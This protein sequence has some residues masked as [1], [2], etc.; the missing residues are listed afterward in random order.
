[1]LD[2]LADVA[3]SHGIDADSFRPL[4]LAVEEVFANCVRHNPT[5]VGPIEVSVGTE[6]PRVRVAI[7]DPDTDEFD[8]RTRSDVPTDLPL[9]QRNPGGLGIHLIRALVDDIE[10]EYEY[11][12][13]KSVTVLVK[14]LR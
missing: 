7:T 12:G 9:D 1:M 3:R 10:Y 11:E 4:Q 5:G 14:T 8:P 2:W 6:G 13:R